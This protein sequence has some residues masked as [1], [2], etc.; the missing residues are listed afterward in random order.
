M[1]AL[2]HSRPVPRISL[3]RTEVALAIGVSLNAIDEMVKE[4]ALPQPRRWRKRK[5]WLVAEIEAALTE[6]PQDGQTP[7]PG[8]AADDDDWV[9]D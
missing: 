3:N 5:I 6:L 1:T 8:E 9:A 2:A 7:A 4:G